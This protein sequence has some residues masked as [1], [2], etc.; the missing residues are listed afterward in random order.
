MK[1]RSVAELLLHSKITKE[2]LGEANRVYKEGEA[3]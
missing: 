3:N 2:K 1:N